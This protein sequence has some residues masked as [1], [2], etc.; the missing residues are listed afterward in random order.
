MR[1]GHVRRQTEMPKHALNDRRLFDDGDQPELTTAAW[2]S[3]HIEAE[4]PPHQVRPE[5]RARS[6][7]D[8]FRPAAVVSA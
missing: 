4:R 1:F 3:Q 2:V 7:C 8:R 6:T 5:E